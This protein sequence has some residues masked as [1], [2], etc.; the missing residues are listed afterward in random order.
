[1]APAA[2]QG[3]ER[4][5]GW[6]D[7]AELS[8]VATDGNSQSE[9]FSLRNTLRGAWTNADLKVTIG[10]LRAASTDVTRSAVG[11][12]AA[13]ARLVESSSTAVTAE[14]YF[15]E[16]RYDRRISDGWYWYASGGWVRNEPAGIRNRSS[17]AAGLGRRWLDTEEARLRVD[18]AATYTDQQDVVEAPGDG[19]GFLGLRL[20]SDYWRQLTATTEYAN[21]VTLD[22]NLD[23]TTDVRA[24]MVNSLSVR[25]SD[26]LAL[27]LSHELQYD[28]APSLIAVPIFTPAG[29]A[30]GEDLLV[31]ADSVDTTL[32]VAL[33]VGL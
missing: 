11:A 8:L 29:D 6:S 28:N 9:T 1:V 27:R 31:E 2:A 24:E 33:V 18:L 16:A 17:V 19:G 20:V 21:L 23:N 14:R 25:I 26:S 5:T 30:V 13:D 15:F 4:E 22:Q 7:E 12:S 3:D 10:G 32:R